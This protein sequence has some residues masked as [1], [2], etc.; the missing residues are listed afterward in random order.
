MVRDGC[1]SCYAKRSN[2]EKRNQVEVIAP[3]GFAQGKTFAQ[4]DKM[5][6]APPYLPVFEELVRDLFQKA[7]RSLE[8]IA[9]SAA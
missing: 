5:E 6:S 1:T 4:N 7:R 9:V 8:D 2:R 3:F